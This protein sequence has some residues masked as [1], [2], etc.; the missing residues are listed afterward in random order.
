[1]YALKL[2]PWF[3]LNDTQLI[4]NTSVQMRVLA[5]IVETVA[6]GEQQLKKKGFKL[7]LQK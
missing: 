3:Y 2:L 6:L 5:G 1:M 7:L 4:D